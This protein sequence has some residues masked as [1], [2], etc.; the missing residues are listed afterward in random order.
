MQKKVL[1]S[2]LLVLSLSLLTLNACAQLNYSKDPIEL[3]KFQ[4]QVPDQND[5]GS[6]LVL[7]ATNYYTPELKNISGDTPLR[8]MD[9]EILGPSMN[10]K[11]WCDVALEGSVRVIEKDQEAKTYNYAGTSDS[12]AVNCKDYFKFD[13]SKTKFVVAHGPW[14]DGLS[15]QYI[16]APFRTLAT[17][18]KMIAAGTVLY[19]PKARGTKIVLPN[20]KSIIHDGY[21]FAADRGGAIKGNHI[22]VFT[23]IDREPS[24]FKWI[25]SK[26]TATFEAY[27]IT[28][29][30]IISQLSEL[31]TP[32]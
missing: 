25:E 22:D 3:D 15:E 7:W 13:V 30:S 5:L 23:G 9:G 8:S 17:D 32:N 20:G 1:L 2:S 19:I 29:R 31:H 4:F 16:L 24:Y 26:S 12:F 27:I 11:T 28:N 21:F 10:R 18:T 14:G 6:K